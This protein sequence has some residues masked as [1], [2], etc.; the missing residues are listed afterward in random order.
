MT[1]TISSPQT[2]EF[3]VTTSGMARI[4]ECSEQTVRQYADRGLIP[5]RRLSNGARTFREADG[6]RLRQIVA[7]RRG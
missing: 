2:D 5:H 6:L 3:S 4:G 1:S 7:S